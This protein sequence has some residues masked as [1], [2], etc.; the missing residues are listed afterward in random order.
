MGSDALLGIDVGTA[1]CKVGLYGFRGDPVVIRSASTP[2]AIDSEGNVTYDPET[3]FALLADLV[4]Q[5]VQGNASQFVAMGIASMAEA[6]LLVDSNSGE[7]ETPIF[8][9]FDQR[10]LPF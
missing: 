10:P 3:L 4:R 5:C 8:A 9:W 1:R 6:G 7:A 2:S